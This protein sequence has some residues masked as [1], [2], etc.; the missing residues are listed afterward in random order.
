M[1]LA[2]FAAFS[3][4]AIVRVAS[5][6]HFHVNCNGHGLVH[7]NS[8]S[9]GYFHSRVDGDPCHSGSR[10]DIGYYHN[11]YYYASASAGTT[12]DQIM[13][14]TECAGNAWVELNGRFSDHRHD[15]H[16]PC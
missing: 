3:F 15:A 13:L 16:D 12:C 10:C 5:A 14:A 7:G 1:L 11:V 9:D 6:S 2:V 4:G 8:T